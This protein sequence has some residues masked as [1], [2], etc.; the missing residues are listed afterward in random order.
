M[1]HLQEH[2]GSTI[3][4]AAAAIIL[5]FTC[6]ASAQAQSTERVVNQAAAAQVTSAAVPSVHRYRAAQLLFDIVS[7]R[8]PSAANNEFIYG[9][10][11]IFFSIF[12]AAYIPIVLGIL[13]LMGDWLMRVFRKLRASFQFLIPTHF[14]AELRTASNSGPDRRG[15]NR[16]QQGALPSKGRS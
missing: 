10:D 15:G 9:D 12:W 8:A 13:S 2:R 5:G 11:I 7:D 14:Q 16:Y 4:V 1:Q 6:V 3:V